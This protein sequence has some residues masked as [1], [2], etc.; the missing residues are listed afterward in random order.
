MDNVTYPRRCSIISNGCF[1]LNRFWGTKIS[2]IFGSFSVFGGYVVE[3]VS[4][5]TS[6]F[7]PLILADYSKNKH[8]E[9][10]TLALHTSVVIGGISSALIGVVI[11]FSIP[12]IS[13]WLSPEYAKYWIWMAIKISWI[14]FYA[15]AGIYAFVFRS[16]NLVK[17]PALITL[18]IGIV[19]VLILGIL[20]KYS[21]GNMNFIP[22]GLGLTGLLS[23]SQSYILNAFWFNHIYPNNGLQIFKNTLIIMLSLAVSICIGKFFSYLYNIK[24][25]WF[26]LIYMGVAALIN[27]VIIYFVIFRKT[28]REIF[29]TVLFKK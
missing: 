6:L 20:Y 3:I 22:Y 17:V 16:H 4:V 15:S 24:N 9:L 25:I 19:N 23:I 11:S 12:F 8:E 29:K 28:Q 18:F 27:I 14:P 7:G 10:Q 26:L 5:V 2:G 21:E 1:F 13:N